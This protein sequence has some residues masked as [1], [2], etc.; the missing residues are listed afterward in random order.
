MNTLAVINAARTL[1]A[2]LTFPVYVG[3]QLATDAQGLLKLPDDAAQFV[4]HTTF[5]QPT[6]QW[7]KA[8]HG[9]VRLQLQAFSRVE[10]HALAMLQA[11]QPLLVAGKFVPGLVTPLG[12]DGPYTGYAQAFERTTA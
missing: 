2:P 3:D 6:H 1:L 10:G 7:G 12:R 8:T 11:A 9:N 5:A 4:L